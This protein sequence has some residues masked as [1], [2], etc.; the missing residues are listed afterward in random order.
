[1]CMYIDVYIYIY[2][3]ERERTLHDIITEWLDVKPIIELVE[4]S[5]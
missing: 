3:L 5:M 4:S 2:I 1:M